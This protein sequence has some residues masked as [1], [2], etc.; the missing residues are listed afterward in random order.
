MLTDEQSRAVR[1][2]RTRH[3]TLLNGGP[4]TG[5]TTTVKS[6]LQP[7]VI[8]DTQ[9]ILLCAPTGTAAERLSQLSS[10]PAYTIMNIFTDRTF[11]ERFMNCILIMDEASMV[12]IQT[13]KKLLKYLNPRRVLLVGDENQLPCI[14]GF[15]VF[16]TLLRVKKVPSVTLTRN[17]RQTGE[18][19]L[20]RMISRLSARTAEGDFLIEPDD[21]SFEVIYVHTEDDMKK[22]VHDLYQRYQPDEDEVE[23]RPGVQI[24]VFTNALRDTLNELTKNTDPDPDECVLGY[25]IGDRIVCTQNLYAK[26]TRDLYAGKT[27]QILVSNGVIG[28]VH[29]KRELIYD[30][31]FIDE[32]KR[33]GRSFNTKFTAARAM[34]VHKSQG[35]EFSE[36]GVIV[37]GGVRDISL[38]LI[39]TAISRF[40][41]RVYMIG[42]ARDV[43]RAFASTFRHPV[44]EEIVRCFNVRKTQ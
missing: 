19:S 6:M 33:G 37:L 5:K 34:T 39:Y 20:T 17:L 18:N 9:N 4:G 10:R 28:R 3:I 36:V 24:L 15:S 22:Q 30:N 14:D 27:R 13:M 21:D 29:S 26:K 41:T 2:F 8:G 11:Q 38:E 23:D 25:H 7:K 31:G 32:I 43:R 16:C 1:L 12:S 44:D 35:N 42:T 40:K